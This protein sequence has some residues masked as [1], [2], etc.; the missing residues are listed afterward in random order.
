MLQKRLEGQRRAD[1]R[2]SAGN[3]AMRA[4][5]FGLLVCGTHGQ[6]KR[7]SKNERPEKVLRTCKALMNG[8]LVDPSFA[9]GDWS[10]RWRED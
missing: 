1:C 10:I 4:I 7:T 9:K 2:E 8:S 6:P 5:G 3:A